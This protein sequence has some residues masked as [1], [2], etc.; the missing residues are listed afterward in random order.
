MGLLSAIKNLLGAQK[1]FRWS[2]YF[3][4]EHEGLKYALH[5][6][7]VIVMLGYLLAKIENGQRIRSHWKVIANHNRTNKHVQIT[8]QDFVNGPSQ[9]ELTVSPKL[10]RTISSIDPDWMAPMGKP[11][12]VDVKANRILPLGASYES[13]FKSEREILQDTQRMLE[14][15]NDGAKKKEF[16]LSD[17]L[18]EVFSR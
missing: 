6:N 3:V 12:L 9:N 7:A 5:E 1:G 16:G 17:V 4:H 14:K 18:R 8:E 11:V 2:L 13:L 10:I 15:L